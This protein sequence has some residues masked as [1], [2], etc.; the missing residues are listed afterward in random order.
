MTW[1]CLKCGTANLDYLDA[2]RTC[3]TGKD[4]SI[5]DTKQFDAWKTSIGEAEAASLSSIPKYSQEAVAQ[6]N[7]GTHWIVLIV[8]IIVASIGLLSLS[9]ITSGLGWLVLAIFLALIAQ[10]VQADIHHKSQKQE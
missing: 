7:M 1:K 5:K 9:G 6:T 2:C 10:V 4:G 8:A 3:G